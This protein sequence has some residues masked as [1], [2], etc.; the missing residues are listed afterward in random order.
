MGSLSYDQWEER[1]H[2]NSTSQ[3][4]EKTDLRLRIYSEARIVPLGL[5]ERANHLGPPIPALL[6]QLG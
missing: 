5:A 4:E 1:L 2:P 6:L 3:A